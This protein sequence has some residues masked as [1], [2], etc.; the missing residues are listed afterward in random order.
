[1]YV[2]Q[3]GLKLEP[4]NLVHDASGLRCKLMPANTVYNYDRFLICHNSKKTE[5]GFIAFGF[6]VSCFI[7]M[8]FE[9]K[10]II[11]RFI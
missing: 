9:K 1:M 11:T 2:N 10:N 8:K 5:P 6:G 4:L 7:N 3:T